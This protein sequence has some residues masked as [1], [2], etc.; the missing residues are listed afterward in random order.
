MSPPLLVYAHDVVS[1]RAG[2]MAEFAT[3]P[4]GSALEACSTS[5]AA[6]RLPAISILCDLDT[7][8]TGIRA[9]GTVCET[10]DGVPIPP[11]TVRRLACDAH[12]VPIL[13]GSTGEV[14][15]QGRRARTAT[16]AQRNTLAAMHQSCAFPGC[17]VGFSACKIHHVE[18]WWEH[19][20][21]TDIENLLPLCEKHHH[22]V[23]EGGWGL[24]LDADR[25][26][27][28]IRP[29][30]TVHHCGTTLDRRPRDV[31]LLR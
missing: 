1:T 23:H 16:P 13:L 25:T 9:T 28:W 19:N 20:G 26:A 24:T 27:T 30:G 18:W 5:G 11:D 8:I 12:I 2:T 7:L 22:T 4:P 3:T 17:T 6:L 15:D 31:P 14:L 29:D 10:D 21:P